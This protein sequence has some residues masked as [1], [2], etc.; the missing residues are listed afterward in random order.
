MACRYTTTNKTREAVSDTKTTMHFEASG[1]FLPPCPPPLST[2]KQHDVQGV[3]VGSFNLKYSRASSTNSSTTAKQQATIPF[4][5]LAGRF[6]PHGKSTIVV[7]TRIRFDFSARCQFAA[8]GSGLQHHRNQWC[9][10]SGCSL[11]RPKQEE[12]CGCLSSFLC[13]FSIQNA[14]IGLSIQRP[15]VLAQLSSPET[16]S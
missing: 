12:C 14:P 5:S 9:R 13:R 16:R 15:Q 11:H 10:A 8:A 2:G 7:R 1:V 6:A 3:G 4:S